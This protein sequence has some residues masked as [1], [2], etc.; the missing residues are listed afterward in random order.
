MLIVSWFARIAR[1]W[2]AAGTVSA[3]AASSG[4]LA[5][6][7]LQS[8]DAQAGYAPHEAQRLRDAAQAWL[9]VVR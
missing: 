4:N 3:P 5:A 6:S 2:P 9:R 1:G 8:A 7:L